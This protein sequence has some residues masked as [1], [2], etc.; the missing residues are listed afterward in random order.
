MRPQ[1]FE[2]K[3]KENVIIAYGSVFENNKC[4][5][6]WTGQNPLIMIWPSFEDMKAVSEIM[7]A[8]V[9]FY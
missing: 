7:N 6:Q 9:F 1:H 3:N 5:M 8:T 4:I 2:I